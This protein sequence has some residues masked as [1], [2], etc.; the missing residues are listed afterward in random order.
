MDKHLTSDMLAATRAGPDAGK[1]IEKL[2]KFA[3]ENRATTFAA[4]AELR[5]GALAAEQNDK[6]KAV[7][8]F[9]AA[10]AEEKADAAFR[11]LGDLLSVQMQMDAGDPATLSGR[12]EPLTVEH[13]PWRFSAMEDQGYLALRTGDKNRA[14]QIF[15]LLSQD[16]TVPQSIGARAKDI[17]RSLN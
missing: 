4:L 9:D 8:F 10:A 12:L 6:V 14:R 5:A 7:T 11:Q 1:S 16:A 2:Q 17:A 3:A 15:T 13:A